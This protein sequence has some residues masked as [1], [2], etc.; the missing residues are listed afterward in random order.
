MSLDQWPLWH[1]RGQL[2][3]VI[4]GDTIRVMEDLG[5]HRYAVVDLRL[6]GVDTPERGQ[7]RWAEATEQTKAWLAEHCP[8][9]L[10][11]YVTEKD[12]RS[13]N[14][15]VAVVRGEDDEVLNEYL[16][17]LGYLPGSNA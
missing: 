3:R 15:Y 6:Q 10:V 5:R 8:T 9:G 16:I 4:D 14:R 11:R 12:R 7:E 2:E 1:Y 17:G 13:F